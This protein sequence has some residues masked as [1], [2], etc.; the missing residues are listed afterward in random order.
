LKILVLGSGTSSGVPV[1]GCG[2]EVCRSSNPK[3]K[4]LRTSIY[5]ELH[6]RDAPGHVLVDTATDLR[7]QALTHGVSRIDAV[8]YTH[9]HADHT[10]GIDDLR[11]FNFVNNSVI[12]CYASAPS[13]KELELRFP[14][15]F[16]PDPDYEGGAP[17]RLKLHEIPSSGPLKLFGVDIL[18]VPVMH[19]KM[20]VL[21]FRFG[22]FAYVT[23]CSFIPESSRV[24]LRDLDCLILDGLRMRP[25]ATH[26]TLAQAIQEIENLRPRRAYLTHIS[27]EIGHDWAN[28]ELKKMTELPVEM[29]YDGLTIEL[30]S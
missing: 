24:M 4:R 21:G 27:H 8:L 14:Y 11:S 2:C 17:P 9:T 25:H 12:D 16:F 23:D 30:A 29:A 28:A 18:P 1:P 6:G 13:K 22:K 19:G 10:F 20:E 5:V 26:F 3:D 15:A 7:L